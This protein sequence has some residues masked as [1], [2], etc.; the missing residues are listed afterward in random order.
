M[1]PKGALQERLHGRKRPYIPRGKNK[2]KREY[3][4]ESKTNNAKSN[5]KSNPEKIKLQNYRRES[6]EG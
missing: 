4:A 6:K 2:R 5:T 3:E 1:W